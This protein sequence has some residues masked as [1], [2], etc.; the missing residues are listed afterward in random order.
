MY[1]NITIAT[2][3]LSVIFLASGCYTKIGYPPQDNLLEQKVTVR[4]NLVEGDRDADEDKYRPTRYRDDDV[5]EE[6]YYYPMKPDD[7]RFTAGYF[8]PILVLPRYSYYDY[9]Y[10][11]YRGYH[12][13]YYYRH[14]DG[15]KKK[16]RK[17]YSKR[18]S[19]GAVNR[20]R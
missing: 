8:Y 3:I 1:K 11:P 14:D 4:E 17:R 6:S 18:Y 10:Y 5:Y 7:F 19:R 15:V 2:V 12:H 16:K 9:S 20:G 13:R